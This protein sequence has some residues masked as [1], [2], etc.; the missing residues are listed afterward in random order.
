MITLLRSFSLLNKQRFSILPIAMSLFLLFGIGNKSQAQVYYLTSDETVGTNAT[1]DALYRMNYDGSSNTAM[2]PSFSY[3]PVAIAQDLA[4]NRLFIFDAVSATRSIKIV[5]ASTGAITAS[6]PVPYTLNSMRYDAATDY[7]Y[8]ITTNSTISTDATDALYK[9]KPSESTPTLIKSS[10]SPSPLYLAL[11]IPNNRVFIYESTGGSS[12]GIKTF[13]LTSNE[14]TQTA[15]INSGTVKDIAYDPLTDYIYYLTSD[16]IA[17]STAATDALNK[18]QPGGTSTIVIKAAVTASPSQSM[19]LDAGNNRAYIYEGVT[20]NRAI[21]AV[22]LTTGDVSTIVSLSSFAAGVTVKSMAVPLAPVLSTSSPTGITSVAATLGGNITKSDVSVTARGI[23]YSSSNNTPTIGGSGVSQAANGAGSGSFSASISSLSAATTYYVRSYAISGAGTSY[24]A[25]SNFSTLSNDNNLSGLSISA[26]TLNPS[27]SAGT[28]SYSTSVTNGTSSITVTPTKNNANA[29]INV[30]GTN[31]NSGAA[32]GSISLGV[33]SNTITV[34]VTAQDNSTKTYTLTVTRAKTPQ[35]ITFNALAAKTY[36]NGDFA[37]GATSTSA[38][39]VSYSSNDNNV[40]TIVNNQ[41]HIVGQGTAT[42]TA[43]QAGDATYLAATSVTQTLTVN[44]AAITV[45]ADVK[46]KVY[47]DA[48]PALTYTVT[49]GALAGGDT[50]TG[51]L[52]RDAGTTVGNYPITKGT[53]AL[54]ANYDLSFV[55]SNLTI[56][57]RPLILAPIP[58]TKVYGN[59]DP[60]FP[61]AQNGTSYASTDAMTGTFSR[62]EGENAGTYALGIGTKRPVNLTTF[63]DMS[64]NYDITFITNNLTITK[65]PLIFHPVPATKVYGNADPTYPYMLDGS[66]VAPGEGITGT[67]GRAAGED[68]GTY[69]LTLGTKR[70]VNV[71]TGVF[72]WDNYEISFVSDNLTITPR[73]LN[74]YAHA[75]SKDYGGSDPALTT[76]IQGS[77][78]D[79]DALT[80]SMVR[81]PG[82]HVGTYAITQGTLA[83]S[84]NYNYTFTGENLTINKKQ[85]N[86]TAN[87]KSKTFGSADPALDYTADALPN[88]ENFSGSLTRTAGED[89]GSYPIAQGSLALSNN[90]TLNFTSADLTIGKKVINVAANTQSK[91]YGNADPTF[92][93]SADALQNGDSFTGSLSRTTGENAGSYPIGLGTLELNNNYSINYTGANLSIGKGTLQYVANPATRY[94]RVNNPVFTGTVTGFANGETIATATTGSLLFSSTATATSPKGFYEINGSGLSAANYDFVQDAANSTALSIVASGDNTLSA[95]SASI[96]GLTPVFSPSQLN[97]GMGV[98]NNVTSFALSATINSSFATAT[99]NGVPYVSGSTKTLPLVAGGNQFAIVVTAQDETTQTYS[100]NIYRA[101]STTNLLSSLVVNGATLSPAFDP[102]VTTYHASVPHSTASVSMYGIAA[103]SSAVVKG[104]DGTVATAENPFTYELSVGEYNYNLTVTSESGAN[105]FYTVLIDRAKSPDATLASFGSELVTMTSPIVDGTLNYSGTVIHTAS[106]DRFNPVSSSG[107]AS[108]KVWVNDQPVDSYGGYY[109]VFGFGTNKLTVEVTSEDGNNTKT[110]NLNVVREKSNNAML[111]NLYIPFLNGGLNESFDGDVYA[112]TA[113]MAD[114]IYT[115]LPLRLHAENEFATVK[116][117]GT[118]VPRFQ[119]YQMALHGGPNTFNIVVTSQDGTQTKAYQ[120]V[121]TRGGTPPP[122]QSPIARLSSLNVSSAPSFSKNFNFSYEELTTIN[123]PNSIASV[124]FFLNKEH[125]NSTITLNGIAYVADLN[126]S[127]LYPIAVGDNLFTVVVTAE[128]GVTTK[129][130]EV[131]VNRLPYVN[132]DLAS[133]S[134][135]K[136][137]LAPAFSAATTTYNVSVPNNVETVT[138]TPTAANAG[139]TVQVNGT[140]IDAANPTATVNVFTGPPS[141]IRTVVRSA[142]GVTSKTYTIIVTRLPSDDA[143]LSS[144]GASSAVSPVFSPS[145]TNY[146]ATVG[147]DVTTYTVAPVTSHA[148]ANIAIAVNGTLYNSEETSSI[149]LEMGLTTIVTTVTAQNGVATETY[150]LKVYRGWNVAKT[151]LAIDKNAAL[152]NITGLGYKNYFASVDFNTTEIRVKPTNLDPNATVT[153]N[154][155]TVTSGTFSAPITLSPDSTMINI[156][157][158]AQDGVT[159]NLYTI[160]VKRNLNNTIMVNNAR[161]ESAL[162]PLNS[163]NDQQNAKNALV[164]HQ[165]LSPNGDGINDYL[166]IEGLDQLNDNQISIIN[167]KGGLIYKTKGYN[168]NGNVFDGHDNNGTMQVP[169]TYYY[170]LEY[171]KGKNKTRKT[172]YIILKY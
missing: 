6:I 112:Y 113:N 76:Y 47:G 82:E 99:I 28:T 33:G 75:Q 19:I 111:A 71:S 109:M 52:T 42:I 105:R 160:K 7:I 125:P 2:V 86:V 57:K 26:G 146:T 133:L 30:N 156:L 110:Y 163:G 166:V 29:I 107:R 103:D 85:I 81:V 88:G 120:L 61:Y 32:S 91:T 80:G 172:G 73:A 58:A 77:L 167:S 149:A 95:L 148:S 35:T 16:D 25:V 138:V 4:N 8:F 43:A 141:R 131:H 34:L 140:T 145:L 164:V 152:A 22:N 135:N 67:F 72:T 17:T 65:R 54:N 139:N 11:D 87:A 157:V 39:V 84:S 170:I 56:T 124:R 51:S 158:T 48:D 74:V 5:N 40:A 78:R 118:A 162:T 98:A 129:T 1:T 132:V 100:L 127:D 123:A 69:A 36:G 134:I 119:D 83:L 89:F 64:A 45:T 55:S 116:V 59:V 49:T 151:V 79:G 3:S 121:F 159:K 136:G 143:T 101:Y 150:I 104:Y 144:L 63:Q 68:V 50:F 60:G 154:G 62:P 46:T 27:F 31:V 117:N 169:G 23:L 165:G 168:I 97:Y 12:R 126:E 108:L 128:D 53:L 137:T 9:V 37:A 24:G 171:K 115:G 41:I 153:V 14:F 70:P 142:D 10:I 106:N 21:K 155:A 66:S 44:K 92:T 130:Y 18:V 13:S 93:Y 90:Y 94:F 96:A 38:L 147:S 114:S 20:A 15:T 102:N 161:N 122:P